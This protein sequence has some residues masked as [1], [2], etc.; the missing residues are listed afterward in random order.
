MTRFRLRTTVLLGIGIVVLAIAAP[1]LVVAQATPE[2]AASPAAGDDAALIQ[3]GEEIYTGVCIACHQAAG[4]G[5]E[6]IYPALA[7]NPFVTLEDP[8]PVV[9]TV[10]YG[11]GGMPRFG[12]I[13]SDEQ[14]AGVVSYIRN[15]WGNR[16][17]VVTPDYVAQVRAEVEAGPEATPVSPSEGQQPEAAGATPPSE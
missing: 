17:S 3:M 11:R 13:Y 1:L 7:G 16:A 2:P 14:I 15:A 4:R 10:L 12:G 9:E 6:G 5:I 8:R